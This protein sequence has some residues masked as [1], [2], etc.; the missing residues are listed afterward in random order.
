MPDHAHTEYAT[1]GE[2]NA[3]GERVNRVEVSQGEE[4][5]KTKRNEQD[6]TRLFDLVGKNAQTVMDFQTATAT[7]FGQIE[8]SITASVASVDKK[9]SNLKW[10]I[11]GGLGVLGVVLRFLI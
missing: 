5:T 3:F 10:W 6:I 9:V 8:T 4:R 2:V 7:R 11:L 1:H